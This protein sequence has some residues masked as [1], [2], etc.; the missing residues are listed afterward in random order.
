MKN[1]KRHRWLVKLGN[2]LAEKAGDLWVETAE[3]HACHG[4]DPG[5]RFYYWRMNWAIRA[6]EWIAAKLDPCGRG[7]VPFTQEE[8]DEIEYCSG[9][10]SYYS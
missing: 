9:A 4:D 2:L 10:L 5:L 3:T 1:T 6:L 7:I 8:L